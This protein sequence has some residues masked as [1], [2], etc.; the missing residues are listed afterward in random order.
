MTTDQL[1]DWWLLSMDDQKVYG[2]TTK[3]TFLQEK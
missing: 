3:M 1:S 2:S